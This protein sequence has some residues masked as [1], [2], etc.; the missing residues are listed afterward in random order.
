MYPFNYWL[1]NDTAE[2]WSDYIYGDM[3][4]TFLNG[5]FYTT[6]ITPG[7]RIVA[8][9]TVLYYKYN[10]FTNSSSDKGKASL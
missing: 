2:I 8:I 7:L 4:D 1:Y 10:E 5:G 9:N 6:V 3:L